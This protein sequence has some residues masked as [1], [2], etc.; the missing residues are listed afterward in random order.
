MDWHDVLAILSPIITLFIL[1]IGGM[2]SYYTMYG[3]LRNRITKLET[4]MQPF[5]SII[6]KELPKL[7]HSPHTPEI[8]VLL[9]K[10]M[11]GILTIDEAK[12]LKERL[13]HELEVLDTAKKLAIVLIIARLDAII[14]GS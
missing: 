4:Q 2:V 10:L 6:E 7:I 12:E 3:E 1:V 11:A 9:D 5:W 14:N 13:K 8:D